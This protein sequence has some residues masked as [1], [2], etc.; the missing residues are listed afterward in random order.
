[1]LASGGKRPAITQRNAEARARIQPFG[2][3]AAEAFGLDEGRRSAS[4]LR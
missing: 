4:R 2:G 1:M 3:C